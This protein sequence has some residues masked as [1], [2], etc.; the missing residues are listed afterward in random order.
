MTTGEENETIL[1]SHRAKLFRFA[2]SVKAE[3]EEVAKKEWKER[4]VGDIKILKHSE[5]SKIR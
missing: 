1:Y 5:T 4:G 2:E 3:G